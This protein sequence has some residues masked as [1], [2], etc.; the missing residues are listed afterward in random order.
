MSAIRSSWLFGERRHVSLL[1]GDLFYLIPAAF[2]WWGPRAVS[3][4]A[5]ASHGAKVFVNR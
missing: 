1:F 3:R 2:C 5:F 4:P